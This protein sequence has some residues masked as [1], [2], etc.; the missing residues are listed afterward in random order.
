MTDEELRAIEARY[1]GAR[2]HVNSRSDVPALVAEVRRLR[3]EYE[4]GWNECREAVTGQGEPWPLL[5]VLDRLARA[6]EH[7]LKDHGCDKHGW[8]SVDHARRWA[9][10]YV[11][12]IERAMTP[13]RGPTT[14][15]EVKADSSRRHPY[16]DDSVEYAER[17][18]NGDHECETCDDSGYVDEVPPG[19]AARPEPR[20]HKSPFTMAVSEDD[21]S[22]TCDASD[23]WCRAGGRA[24]RP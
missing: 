21:L 1:V 16:G 18:A 24:G 6:S 22:T 12:R 13:A 8:E 20:R 4:R 5:D 14:V 7:L 3:G 9:D 10:E 15:A 17:E 19:Q 11:K 2:G 23:C